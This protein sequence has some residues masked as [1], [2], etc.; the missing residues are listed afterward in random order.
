VIAPYPV[1]CKTDILGK[2]VHYRLRMGKKEINLY[3]GSGISGT[4]CDKMYVEEY[5]SLPGGFQLPVS[6][7][8]ET[9]V[10]YADSNVIEPNGEQTQTW[11]AEFAD[12]YLSGQMV[13]GSILSQQ[14]TWQSQDT[15]STLTGNYA[16]LEMIGKVKIEETLRK[17][18][19]DN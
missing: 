9:C 8:R 10:Y 12:K 7:I 6:F 5:W 11:V 3:N 2:S 13:A 17:N 1:A 16:C 18:A 4:S 14:V 19:E 15:Y